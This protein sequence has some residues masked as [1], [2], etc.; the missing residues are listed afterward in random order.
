MQ[1]PGAG[2]ARSSYLVEGRR[3]EDKPCWKPYREKGVTFT[4]PSLA[5]GGGIPISK[6]GFQ[7]F[8]KSTGKR[9]NDQKDNASCPRHSVSPEKSEGD[10]RTSMSH[11]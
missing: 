3:E 10:D 4:Q 6:E 1:A 5:G 9:G 8:A 11:E 2:S 7:A